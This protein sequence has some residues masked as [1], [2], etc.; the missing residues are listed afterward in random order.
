MKNIKI[1]DFA[2]EYLKTNKG[3]KREAVIKALKDALKRKK[4]GAKCCVCG[5]PIWAAGCAFAG[6]DMCFTC[7]TGEADSSEDYEIIE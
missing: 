6:S 3:E 5:A 7:M 2:E 4:N 1:N